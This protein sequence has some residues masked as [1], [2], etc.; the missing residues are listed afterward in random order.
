MAENIIAFVTVLLV[1]IIFIIIGVSQIRSKEPVGFYSG[2]K[3][4]KKEELMDMGAW[5][6]KHGCMWIGYGLAFIIAFIICSF[7]KTEGI[8][9]TIMICVGFGWLVIMMLYHC[10]LKKTYYR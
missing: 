5:N 7:V 8:A 3:P 1:S 6:K 2:V 9:A 4:P 10:Y